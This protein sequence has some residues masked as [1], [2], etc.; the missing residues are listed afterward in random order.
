MNNVQTIQKWGNG[1][2]VRL[3]KRVL[4]EVHLSPNQQV[5]VNIEN[6]KI[7]LTPIP[8]TRPITLEQLL[9]NVTPELIGGEI[10][11]GEDSGAEAYE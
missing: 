3:P 7:I 1:T 6:G 2:G 10:F 9:V 8:D 5:E 4:E 11:W